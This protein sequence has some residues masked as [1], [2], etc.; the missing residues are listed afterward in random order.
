MKLSRLRLI[1]NIN[2]AIE[3]INLFVN[4]VKNFNYDIDVMSGRYIVDAK[5]LMGLFSLDL[6]SDLTLRVHAD[7]CDDLIAELK[8]LDFIPDADCT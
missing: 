3:S 1:T 4:T 6:S 8:K 5:S 2:N 7:S